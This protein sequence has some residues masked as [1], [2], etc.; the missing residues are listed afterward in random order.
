MPCATEDSQF[1]QRYEIDYVRV[2]QLSDQLQGDANQDG[3]L[4]VLDIVLIISYILGNVEFSDS[5]K[6]ISDINL[7]G[8]VNVMDVVVLVS[9]II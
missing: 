4:D 6:S 3:V 8:E 2:Y 7:D 1:P 9:S 5:Q